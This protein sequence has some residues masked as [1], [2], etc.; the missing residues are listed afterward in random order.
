MPTR[1]DGRRVDAATQAH[2]RRSAVK[3]V[4]AGM[5]QTAAAATFGVSVRAVNKWMALAVSLMTVGR[6]LKAW[7]FSVQK[8]VHRASERNDVAIARWLKTEYPA[9]VRDAK[10][11]GAT[12][13][14]GDEMGLRSDHVTETSYGLVG[15]TPVV[16]ATGRRVGCSMIS[17][18]TNRD[19]LVFWFTRDVSRA[20]VRRLH[21]APPSAKHG[22][23]LP[24]SR[25]PPHTSVKAGEGPCGREPHRLPP[26]SIAELLPRTH[27]RRAAESGLKINELGKSRPRTGT[28]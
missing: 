2:V 10:R 11:E 12:I 1:L 9:I 6:Y 19:Q 18:I 24:H 17:A 4:R 13:Y 5:T 20:E 15:R 26:D 8:P 14:L 25:R 23:G 22:Q 28:R 3:A 21:A 7:G 27:P 16:R